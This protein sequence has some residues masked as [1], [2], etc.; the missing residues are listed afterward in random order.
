MPNIKLRYFAQLRELAQ[1]D[2]ET[3]DSDACDAKSLYAEIQ[4]KYQFPHRQEQLMLAINGDFC[5]WDAPLKAG[6]EV[7]FIPPVAGG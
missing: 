6:D 7:A 4:S 3:I 1:R 5:A 2:S